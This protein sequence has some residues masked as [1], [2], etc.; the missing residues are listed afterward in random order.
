MK[1]AALLAATALSLAAPVAA[2]TFTTPSDW[3]ATKLGS[4]TV[5]T[6]PEP[7]NALAIVNV[8]SASNATDA[9][10]KAWVAWPGHTPPPP[11]LVSPA[12]GHD[13]WDEEASASYDL[14]P[15]AKKSMVAFA[16][17]K[18]TTWTVALIDMTD[19][20][21]EKRSGAVRTIANSIRPE[22]F[23]R[24]SFVGRTSHPLD[25]TRIAAMRQF[26]ADG[27]KA[28]GVP[29]AGV[30]LIENGKIVWEGGVGV[31]RL[32]AP[33]PVDAHTLFMIASNTKGMSTLL[34]ST[35][36]DEGKLSWDQPVTQVYP[37]FRLGS[38]ATTRSVLVKHLVCA[39]T[40]LPRKDFDWIFGS[41][42]A[43]PATETFRQLAGTEPTSGFGQLFQYNNLMASAAGYVGGHL[44]HPNMEI[45]AAYDRAMDERIFGPLGMRD[46]TFSMAKALG[47]NHAWPHGWGFGTTPQVGSDDF[48]YLVGPYRP[49]GG[50]WSSAHDMAQYVML[51][52][53]KGVAPSG[54]R[55]VSES[56]LLARR[57]RGVPTG[58]DEYYG[59]GLEE[60]VEGGISVIH[61]GGSMAGYKSDWVAIPSAGVGAVLLTNGEEGRPLLHPFMRRLVE[62]MYDGKPEAVDDVAAAG[63]TM[64][65]QALKDQ[66]RLTIPADP[67][68]LAALA[69][70]YVNPDLGN[71]VVQRGSDPTF[72]FTAWN[73]TVVTRREDDGTLS[74]VTT[75]PLNAGYVFVVGMKDGKRTLITRDGQHEYVFVETP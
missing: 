52:L 67:S 22:G 4:G 19:A 31:K 58:E 57:A 33:D 10:A 41:S 47:G 71:I 42:R 26:V 62:L 73:S 15:N 17:R 3:T 23:V 56:A 13:G 60:R 64:R 34:L 74:F 8:A 65:A 18:G 63:A 69:P 72:K 7:G 53:N 51:E 21:R 37:T 9:I 70:H 12:P 44:I 27:L 55:L 32:G 61:H 75:D 28:L 59:M 46:T 45:G 16:L 29:G 66:A 20:A 35:L 5:L 39:C 36:V 49:A 2:Q 40:G 54:K 30:A 43:T 14:S 6:P 48:N 50:A 38:D 1:F 24:E 11:K 25:T 68:A